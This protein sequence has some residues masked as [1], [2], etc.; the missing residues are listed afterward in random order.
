V[1]RKTVIISVLLH[2]GVGALAL[3]VATHDRGHRA[4]SV[5]VFGNKEK[6]RE[7]PR[8]ARPKPPARPSRP[9]SS[10][11]VERPSEEPSTPL[12]PH[13][14]APADAALDTEV[15]LD[16][17]GEGDGPVIPVPRPGGATPAPTVGPERSSAPRPRPPS[18]GP[19]KVPS[20]EIC[21]EPETKPAPIARP[22]EIEYTAEA[23]SGGVEGRLVLR[24][25]V[26]ADGSVLKVEVVR[27][28]EAS[29]DAAAVAAVR[30]W[31]FRPS[32]RCGKPV[33]GGT[34]TLARRFELGD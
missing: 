18:R 14:P 27:G 20:E 16:N 6:K 24:V 29:L 5:A 26:G 23:R 10:P 12:T 25:T 7:R 3:A 4:T 17:A 11:R 32:S 2:L 30:T 1:Y 22:V 13:R 9:R 8:G 21:E 15:A 19:S 34:F 33:T 28:V 31:T